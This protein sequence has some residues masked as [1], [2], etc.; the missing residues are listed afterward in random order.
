MHHR[1]RIAKKLLFVNRARNSSF[2]STTPNHST[3][4]LA[5]SP[6]LQQQTTSSSSSSEQEKNPLEWWIQYEK[7][8]K[9]NQKK[10]ISVFVIAVLMTLAIVPI[11]DPTQRETI[12]QEQKIQQLSKYY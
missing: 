4:P 9:A 7:Q 2:Y 11:K 1:V 6:P 8:K 12:P 3:T 5:S 10:K